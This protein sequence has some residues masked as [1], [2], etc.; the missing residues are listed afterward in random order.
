MLVCVR[1][2]NKMAEQVSGKNLLQTVRVG[3]IMLS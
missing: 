3:D 1:Y 2:Q